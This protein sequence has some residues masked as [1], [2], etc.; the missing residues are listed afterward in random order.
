MAQTIVELDKLS[1]EGETAIRSYEPGDRARPKL[2]IDAR[3]VQSS[4][5]IRK[6]PIG[7]AECPRH[8]SSLVLIAIP[9]SRPGFYYGSRPGGAGLAGFRFLG[10]ADLW[11]GVAPAGQGAQRSTGATRSSPQGERPARRRADWH[12]HAAADRASSRWSS[13]PLGRRQRRRRGDLLLDREVR[14]RHRWLDDATS[15]RSSTP[16]NIKLAMAGAPR[17]RSARS[18]PAPATSSSPRASLSAR[19][20]LALEP[21]VDPHGGIPWRDHDAGAREDGRSIS[22]AS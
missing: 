4:C 12:G 20:L 22:P 15:P 13:T 3:D 9:S 17:W 5:A 11:S 8:D 19:R 7:A 2:S 14:H 16:R 18:P 10:E 6:Q 21:S 1:A